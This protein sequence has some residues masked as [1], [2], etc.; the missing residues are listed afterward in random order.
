VIGLPLV[1]ADLAPTGT[2]RAVF[3]A[4]NPVQGRVDP[5]T[6]AITGPVADLVGELGRRFN[7]PVSIT[8]VPDASAV[9]DRVKSHQA[10]IGFLAY[11]AARAAQV[12][13]SEPYALMASAYVVRADSTLTRSADLDHA[14]VRIGAVSGQ[15]QQI[16]VSEHI[17]QAHIEVLPAMPAHDVLTGLLV[18]GKLDAFAANRQRMEEAARTSPRLRVLP[19]NFL[20]IGQAIVVEKGAASR[21][22]ELNRF[23]RDVLASGLVKTSLDRAKLVGVDVAPAVPQTRPSGDE[24]R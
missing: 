10:D 9:I 12:D 1:S 16:F 4:T 19:D 17:K 13:Y 24:R 21:L 2:L 20:V 22:A 5:A 8:P 6:G 15:S 7:V 23:V 18:D 3:L 14:G 11:E